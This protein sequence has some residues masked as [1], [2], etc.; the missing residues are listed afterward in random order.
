MSILD[1]KSRNFS[2]DTKSTKRIDSIYYPHVGESLSTTGTRVVQIRF[3]APE[4]GLL[5]DPLNSYLGFTVTTSGTNEAICPNINGI[6]TDYRV[7]INNQEVEHSQ[8]FGDRRILEDRV[9]NSKRW[10]ESCGVMLSQQDLTEANQQN[11][12]NGGLRQAVR[13]GGFDGILSRELPAKNHIFEVQYDLTSSVDTCMTSDS[14]DATLAVSEFELY[15]AWKKNPMKEKEIKRVNYVEVGHYSTT[16]ANGATSASINIPAS[17]DSLKMITGYMRA[18]AS[19]TSSSI[20]LKRLQTLFNATTQYFYQ[21]GGESFP[22]QPVK[23]DNGV[24]ALI[25]HLDCF[26]QSA[27]IG[28]MSEASYFAGDYDASTSSGFAMC[29]NFQVDKRM[30]SGL[31]LNARSNQITFKWQGTASAASTVDFF[32]YNNRTWIP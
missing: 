19:L 16:L 13:L 17:A 12:A 8:N 14:A 3:Q 32:L 9:L 4:P 21:I 27:L 20:Y 23:C 5:F 10:V 11:A 7:R 28:S 22:N 31:D 25:R 6:F 1:S 29:Y 15:I 2:L 30:Q 26:S 24:N 18:T